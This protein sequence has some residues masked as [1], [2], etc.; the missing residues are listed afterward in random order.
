MFEDLIEIKRN[1]LIS[2]LSPKDD[3][4]FEDILLI[5]DLPEYIKLYFDSYITASII[6]VKYQLSSNE[7]INFNDP[8]MND[9]LMNLEE[10]LY[11]KFHF[12]LENL[13]KIIT[14][15]T[16]LYLNFLIR[17]QFTLLNFLFRDE[18][19]VQ[20]ST[21][22]ERM[23]YFTPNIHYITSL[24]LKL[25]EIIFE[26]GNINFERYKFRKLL[27][28]LENENRKNLNAEDILDWFLPLFEFM[29]YE[30]QKIPISSVLLYLDDT[31]LTGLKHFVQ[32]YINN[33]EEFLVSK[34]EILN[35][36]MLYQK[37]IIDANYIVGDEQELQKEID[38]TNFSESQE[39]I[40]EIKSEI[41]EETQSENP[42]RL[43]DES[44]F[45]EIATEAKEDEEIN[46]DELVNMIIEG[47]SV[48]A[49]ESAKEKNIISSVENIDAT[50]EEQLDVDKINTIVSDIA[51]KIDVDINNL[52]SPIIFG[53]EAEYDIQI[54]DDGNN[55]IKMELQY[56]I[57]ELK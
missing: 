39:A 24:N 38:F 23:K 35:L 49:P 45:E 27:F 31:G 3:F 18:L 56:I 22:Q 44:N 13:K 28:S 11:R 10:V 53:D 8:E 36:L 30:Q 19:T 37:Q 15:A 20:L 5:Q 7:F 17:P 40:K 12:S 2:K 57:N 14:K 46:Y 6:Q 34:E 55:E 16:E 25:Q 51:R 50:E 47:T 48:T 43:N 42:K 32:N 4:I 52:H 1:D 29:G 54:D 21:I 26:S 9:V 41:K 33:R